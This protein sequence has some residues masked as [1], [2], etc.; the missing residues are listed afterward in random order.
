MKIWINCPVC[1]EPLEVWLEEGAPYDDPDLAQVLDQN[2]SCD[3]ENAFPD[4]LADAARS[5]ARSE[6][7]YLAELQADARR[8]EGLD[9]E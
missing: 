9:Y 4:L 8:E 7:Q 5:A 1:A 3:L 2:C 6:A